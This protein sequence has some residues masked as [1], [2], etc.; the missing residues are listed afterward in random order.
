MVCSLTAPKPEFAEV[1]DEVRRLLDETEAARAGLTFGVDA[2]A[3]AFDKV[4]A[5]YKLPRANEPERNTRR[6]AIGRASMD[7][8]REPLE[9]A[10]LC[11]RLLDICTRL[12]EIGNP[13]V[14]S[15]VIVSAHLARAAL[16]S[17]AANVE[18]NL[19][20]ID[21]DPFC[22]EAR[23]ELEHLLDGRDAQV[24]LIVERVKHRT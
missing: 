4:A 15:D 8:A 14:L 9:V 22:H 17:A 24:R 23:K 13:R 2:D 11:A 12:A 6:A 3:A 21:D 7:A 20:S 16:L 18:V 5:A 19:P 10:H 1:A